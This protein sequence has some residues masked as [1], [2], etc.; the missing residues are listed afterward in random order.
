LTEPGFSNKSDII[1]DGNENVLKYGFT[2]DYLNVIKE[3]AND[4]TKSGFKCSFSSLNGENK[5]HISW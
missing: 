1:Y 2:E 3:I 5:L 4:I